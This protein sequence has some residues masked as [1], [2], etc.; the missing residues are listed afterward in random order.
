MH[1]PGCLHS[2]HVDLKRPG[3][4]ASPCRVLMAPVGTF[5]QRNGEQSVVHRCLGCGIERH[6]RVAADD[7]PLLLLRLP[8]YEPFAATIDEFEPAVEVA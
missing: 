6:N 8:L 4:R 3:D 2:L 5:I 1:Q 7:N